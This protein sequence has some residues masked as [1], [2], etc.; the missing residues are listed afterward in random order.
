[1]FSSMM[2]GKLIGN[3]RY[4][5]KFVQSVDISIIEDIKKPSFWYT[6]GTDPA[7]G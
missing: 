6:Q 3:N 7:S 4:A 2:F 1:M 5:D